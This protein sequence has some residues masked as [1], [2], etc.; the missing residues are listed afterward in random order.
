VAF[1]PATINEY[2]TIPVAL[3]AVFP[4][5]PFALYVLISTY[6]LCADANGP[7]LLAPG[8]YWDVSIIVLT[9]ALFWHLWRK[10]FLQLFQSL[11]REI[12]LQLG[13]SAAS[14]K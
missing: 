6:H 9:L 11:R 10:Q 13:M 12:E 3:A 7:H 4:S 5:V 14:R 8:C 1:S 2:L